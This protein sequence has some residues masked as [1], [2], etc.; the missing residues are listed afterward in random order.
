MVFVLLVVALFLDH[1]FTH[2]TWWSLTAFLGYAGTAIWGYDHIFFWFFISIQ[3][4]VIV[5]VL[6]MSF[7]G[8]CELLKNAAADHSAFVYIV[9]NFLMHY[10]GLLLACVLI[11]PQKL[12]LV[13]DYRFGSILS[14]YGFFISYTG[15]FNAVD[16]YGCHF[17]SRWVVVGS[18]T[19]TAAVCLVSYRFF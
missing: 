18:F 13:R 10:L 5:G 14:A 11:N 15:A 4:N 7:V 1:D 19:T 17:D 9:G 3:I 16:V 2:F 6:G 8:Q 12:Q